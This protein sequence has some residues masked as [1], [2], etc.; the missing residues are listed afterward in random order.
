[1]QYRLLNGKEIIDLT[2]EEEE[3]VPIDSPPRAGSSEISTSAVGMSI[4]EN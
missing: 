2:E 1:M 4:V 3:A